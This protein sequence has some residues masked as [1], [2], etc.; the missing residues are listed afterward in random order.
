MNLLRIEHT[1]FKLTVESTRFNAMWRKGVGNLGA[2][3][4]TS[5]YRWSDDVQRV[6]LLKENDEEREI[7]PDIGTEPTVLFTQLL[8]D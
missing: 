5:T 4:L 2:E 6:M 3:K 8:K 1:D 7:I